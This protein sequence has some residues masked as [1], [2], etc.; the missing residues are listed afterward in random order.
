MSELAHQA[1]QWQGRITEIGDMVKSQQ[2]EE[3]KQDVGGEKGDDA[4]DIPDIGAVLYAQLVPDRQRE[5]LAAAAAIGGLGR[6]LRWLDEKV[7]E[8]LGAAAV[9]RFQACLLYTSPSPRDRTRSRMPSS[10]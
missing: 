7:L 4:G 6:Q 5:A 10:A 2:A 9:E 8:A 3:E 1:R